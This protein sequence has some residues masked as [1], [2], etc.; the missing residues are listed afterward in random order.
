MST[1]NPYAAPRAPVADAA[2]AGPENFIPAGRA[3]RAARGWAWIAAAWGLF[4]RQPLMWILFAVIGIMIF[5]ALHFFPIVGQIVLALLAPVFTGGVMMGCRDLEQAS[6]LQVSHLFA[7]FRERF[8]NLL[9]VGAISLALS[10]A[11]AFIAALVTGA[12]MGTLLGAGADPAAVAAA[13]VTLLL[14]VL[15]MLAL[16]VPVS[17]AMWFA[18]ALVALHGQ[19][20]ALAM[21][22]SFLACL[23]NIMPF[24]LYGVIGLLLAMAASIPFG[25]GWLVLGPVT[26]ASLY[27][28]YRDIFFE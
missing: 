25:L 9:L 20:P 5:V 16:L 11:I 28:G 8:G 10:F 2:V 17:M 23:K 21:K 24:L 27:T 22:N 4:K 19:G 13:G 12:G 18:P 3:V 7:G 1:P 6:E 15:I 14:A 26:V